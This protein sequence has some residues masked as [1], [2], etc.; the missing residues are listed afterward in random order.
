MSHED[1]I[2]WDGPFAARVAHRRLYS[3][4]T[5]DD[6]LIFRS[7]IRDN[8]ALW[9]WQDN[10]KRCNFETAVTVC[11]EEMQLH[12]DVLDLIMAFVLG[13]GVVIPGLQLS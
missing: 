2:E 8:M 11:T 13:E 10:H 3:A 5:Y 12:H 4:N 7:L 6:Q 9:M 1:K